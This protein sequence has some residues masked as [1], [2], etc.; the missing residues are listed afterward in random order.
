MF[1]P[2]PPHETLAIF[3]KQISESSGMDADHHSTHSAC[4]RLGWHAAWGGW[5]S[6]S[7]YH[8]AHDTDASHH[9]L[10]CHQFFDGFDHQEISG[11]RDH[12][13]LRCGIWN[14]P[15]SHQHQYAGHDQ[16][17][18]IVAGKI[19]PIIRTS[20][21][22]TRL[23]ADRSDSHFRSHHFI[24]DDKQRPIH[25]AGIQSLGRDVQ[26]SDSSPR[27]GSSMDCFRKTIPSLI[28]SLSLN[29]VSPPID[30]IPSRKANVCFTTALP[31]KGCRSANSC[32]FVGI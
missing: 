3:S 13:W 11:V 12:L 5:C 19:P 30:Y 4:L 32:N 26:V 27:R 8:P 18:E 14:R 1:S 2:D 10:R 28:E 20:R 21:C 23:I 16:P 15:D 9:G 22:G 17:S 6:Q 24:P 7:H 25:H 29:L 31:T